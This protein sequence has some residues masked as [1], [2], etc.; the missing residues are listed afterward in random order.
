MDQIKIKNLEVFGHHG[1]L[2]EENTL[3]QKF[4]INA[5]LYTDVE[6][7]GRSDKMSSSIHYGE[8][9]HLINQFMQEQTFKLIET[10]AEQLARC[11]LL[12]YPRLKKIRL[13][14]LKPWAPI[15][16]PLESV[17]VEIVRG[18]K[19]AY[20]SLG[21][22][23]G[24]REQYLQR[25]IAALNEN[26]A[27]RVGKVASFLNTAP[28]GKTDQPDFLNTAVEIE[29]LL[30]PKQLL[31]VTQAIEQANGRERKE[32]WGERTLD[33]DILLYS[34]LVMTDAQLMIPHPDM[35]N[36]LFVLAPMCEIAPQQVHPLLN[37]TMYCLKN[38]LDILS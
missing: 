16:L 18:W 29:T 2:P 27:I 12:E 36:R 9:C 30:E 28:Y 19:K 14:V 11:L 34:N 13:E 5:V 21:S 6:D 38:K 3:G 35:H 31:E 15:G 33:I 26:E 4:L 10:V 25:A 23:L 17:S 37:E 1:V 20:L 22:N 32:H 24:E 7:A 8:V